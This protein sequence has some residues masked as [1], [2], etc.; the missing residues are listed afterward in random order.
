[1][2]ASLDRREQIVR[3]RQSFRATRDFFLFFMRE[4]EDNVFVYNQQRDW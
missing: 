2:R 3:E 1:M 4:E